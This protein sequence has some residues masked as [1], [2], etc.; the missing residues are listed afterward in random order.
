MPI[1]A[2]RFAL[3]LRHPVGQDGDE[4]EIVDAEDDL[5]G[6]Q[7]EQGRPGGRIGGKRQQAVHELSDQ[8]A[9]MPTAPGRT[10]K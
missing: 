9:N 7:G 1:R 5:H 8:G 2:A 10:R 6:H 4:N 3:V